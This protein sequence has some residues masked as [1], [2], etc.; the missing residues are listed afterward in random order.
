MQ[1]GRKRIRWK[2]VLGWPGRLSDEQVFSTILVKT[3][4]MEM[5]RK[6]ASC[7]VVRVFGI[8]MM[9]ARFHCCGTVEVAIKRLNK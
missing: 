2:E 1:T 6:S 9:L 4:V 3:G 8:G 5:G 7:L